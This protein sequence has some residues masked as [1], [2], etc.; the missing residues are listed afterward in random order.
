MPKDMVRNRYFT[1]AVPKNNPL[2]QEAEAIHDDTN[3]P[4]GQVIVFY[5]SEYVRLMRSGTLP[6]VVP[7]TKQSVEQASGIQAITPGTDVDERELELYGDP[8]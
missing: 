7:V 2:L 3:I 8:D 4:E 5:A 1:I 6:S